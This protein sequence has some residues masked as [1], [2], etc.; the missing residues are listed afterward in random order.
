PDRIHEIMKIYYK[1]FEIFLNINGEI[2]NDIVNKIVGTRNY[3]THR[4]DESKRKAVHGYKGI[5]KLKSVVKTLIHCIIMND[6]GYDKDVIYNEIYCK[7][8]FYLMLTQLH[9]KHFSWDEI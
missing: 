4:S 7:E 3:N 8:S 1:I 2:K 6:M 5:N 9:N